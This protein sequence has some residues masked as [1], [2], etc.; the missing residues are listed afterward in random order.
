MMSN[1]DGCMN[2]WEVTRFCF[3]ICVFHWEAMLGSVFL[4]SVFLQGVLEWGQPILAHH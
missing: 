1:M 2:G 3:G 4:D